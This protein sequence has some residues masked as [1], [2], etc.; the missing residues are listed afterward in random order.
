MPRLDKGKLYIYFRTFPSM[1]INI[2][3][4]ITDIYIIKR[5]AQTLTL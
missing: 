1:E 5:N 4:F 2:R 3:G